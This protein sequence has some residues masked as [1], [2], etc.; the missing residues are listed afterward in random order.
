MKCPTCRTEIPD[1]SKFCLH[2]GAPITL[3]D[4]DV[5]EYDD[6]EEYEDEDY[7]YEDDEEYEDEEVEAAIINCPNCNEEISYTSTSCPKCMVRLVNKEESKIQGEYEYRDFIFPI[8]GSGNW[9]KLHT[10]LSVAQQYWTDYQSKILPEIQKWLDKG[11]QTV[12]EVG[13]SAIIIEEVPHGCFTIMFDE[14]RAKL[15]RNLEIKEIRVKLRR[16]LK[17]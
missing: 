6:D 13:A 8:N 2:C 11:W 3:K 5:E 15:T 1:K 12:S 10:D 7:E 14:T 17:K 9:G 16:K 4:V